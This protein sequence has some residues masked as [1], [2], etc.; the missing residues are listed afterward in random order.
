[1]A[2]IWVVV[3]II[4]KATMHIYATA[5]ETLESLYA[6]VKDP[7]RRNEDPKCHNLDQRQPDI[8]KYFFK[9]ISSKNILIETSRTVFDHI[10]ENCGSATLTHTINY[11]IWK[12]KNKKLKIK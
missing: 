2:T 10:L 7:A 9:S 11:F 8:S 4:N 12:F 5:T 6:A 3:T 1:M